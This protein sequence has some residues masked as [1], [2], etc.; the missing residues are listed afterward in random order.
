MRKQPH[1]FRIL[2]FSLLGLG[3][4]GFGVCW[5]SLPACALEGNS[6]AAV[7]L[8]GADR[9]AEI[10]NAVQSR[11]YHTWQQL[12]SGRSI[13]RSVTLQNFDEYAQ[14]WFAS[15]SGNQAPMNAFKQK[16]QMYTICPLSGL[17]VPVK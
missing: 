15:V 13:A 10:K 1:S 17:R 2:I 11:D 14:A 7:G 6:F 4:L 9:F 8:Y 3:L 16:Y 12:M 5:I